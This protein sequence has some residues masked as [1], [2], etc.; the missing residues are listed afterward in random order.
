MHAVLRFLLPL[1]I[2]VGATLTLAAAVPPQL[3]LALAAAQEATPEQSELAGC[4]AAG[5][6]ADTCLDEADGKALVERAEWL[7]RAGGSARRGSRP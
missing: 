4:I 1:A 2:A 5:R 6:D 7:A 3:D